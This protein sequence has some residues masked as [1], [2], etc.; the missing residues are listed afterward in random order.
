MAYVGQRMFCAVTDI[1]IYNYH[2]WAEPKY[3]HGYFPSRLALAPSVIAREE[4]SDR[5]I[6]SKLETQSTSSIL[7]P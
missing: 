5:K 3:D 2:R 1:I 7:N 6:L 4:Q